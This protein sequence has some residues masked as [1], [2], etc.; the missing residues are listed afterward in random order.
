[1]K[2]DTEHYCVF[3]G[4]A[5]EFVEWLRDL[6]QLFSSTSLTE[7]T[8]PALRVA[9]LYRQKAKEEDFE[10]TLAATGLSHLLGPFEVL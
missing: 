6:N 7:I 9:T 4:I 1:M 2:A 5:R 3:D 8:K 10:P